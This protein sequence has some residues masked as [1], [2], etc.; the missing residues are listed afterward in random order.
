MNKFHWCGFSLLGIMAMSMMVSCGKS[1]DENVDK[2]FEKME[3]DVTGID[4]VNTVPENDTLNQFIYHYL[5]NGSGVAIGDIN[6]DGLNDL[7]FTGNEQS[8]RLYLNK[9]DFKFEDITEKSGTGTKQWISGVTMVDV[10][11]DGWLD[12]LLGGNG[13]FTIIYNNKGI[14]DNRVDLKVGNDDVNLDIG[15]LDLNKD[16]KMDL[17]LN[18]TSLNY[19]G[20]KLSAFIQIDNNSFSNNTIEY[21]N[22]YEDNSNGT[23]IKWLRFFD[24]DKD[25]DVDIVGDGLYGNLLKKKIWW[26]NISNKFTLKN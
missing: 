13:T 19:N 10:N 18:S 21:F 17:I 25:G 22:Q 1:S 7:Y 5:Y 15:F 4:F 12:L 8:S 9:G 26:E 14:F 6:N 24:Y 2:L 11:N 23:W 16:G 3:S 20:Y